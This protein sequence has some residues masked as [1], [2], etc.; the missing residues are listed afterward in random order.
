MTSFSEEKA[1]RVKALSVKFNQLNISV[2]KFKEY[3]LAKGITREDFL[4]TCVGYQDVYNDHW[5][6][7]VS[8]PVFE[9][10]LIK[11]LKGGKESIKRIPPD[12][13]VAFT[14]DDFS[15][16][17]RDS[18]AC[19]GAYIAYYGETGPAIHNISDKHKHFFPNA[20][21]S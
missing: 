8:H 1:K 10:V 4:P 20:F 21:S 12:I 3:C 7:D 19:D 13:R 16:Q 18:L 11:A 14:K 5:D 15:F 17:E 9:S 2:K 6:Y